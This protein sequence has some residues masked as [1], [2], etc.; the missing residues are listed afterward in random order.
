QSDSA[1]SLGALI[2]FMMLGGRVASP[3]VSLARLLQDVQEARMALAQ[4][5]WVLNRQ[6]ERHGMTQGLRPAFE[7]AI[8]FDDVTFKYE[9]TTSPALNGVNFSIAPGTMLGLVGRSGSGKSTITRLL[10]G[11][12]RNYSGTVKIDGMDLREVNLRHLRQS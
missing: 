7:G 10:M 3:L 8:N 5:A 11:I 12:N 1:L 2:G 9:G 6:T 4:V